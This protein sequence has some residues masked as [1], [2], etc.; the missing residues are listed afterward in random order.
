MWLGMLLFIL[1]VVQIAIAKKLL[2][3]PFKWHRT[4]GYT[5]LLLAMLHGF[6]AFGLYN[7]LFTL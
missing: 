4:I 7:G 5:I 2:P 6:L 1:V 3:V